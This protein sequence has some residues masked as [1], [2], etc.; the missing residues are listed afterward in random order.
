MIAML[1]GGKALLMLVD[2]KNNEGLAVPF[3]GRAAMNRRR[4]SC[5]VLA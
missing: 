2:Q 5:R 1:K 4:H 3:F